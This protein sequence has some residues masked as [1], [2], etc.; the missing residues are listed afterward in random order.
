MIAN[1]PSLKHSNREVSQSSA[2]SVFLE[3]CIKYFAKLALDAGMGGRALERGLPSDERSFSEKRLWIRE[4][5]LFA[6]TKKPLSIHSPTVSGNPTVRA[7]DSVTRDRHRVRIG[8]TG[9]T[10]FLSHGTQLQGEFLVGHRL[11]SWNFF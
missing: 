4:H 3:A 8:S 5:L 11:A 6:L 7:N 9:F 1:A 10:N 2:S